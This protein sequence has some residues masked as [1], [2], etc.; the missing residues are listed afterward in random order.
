MPES[1]EAFTPETVGRKYEVVC[2]G[3][4]SRR[5]GGDG[6]WYGRDNYKTE[7]EVRNA[8]AESTKGSR[9]QN[10]GGITVDFGPDTGERYERKITRVVKRCEVLAVATGPM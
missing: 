10:V 3:F 8:L 5:I 4:L 1:K 6:K 7:S 2:Y 9:T